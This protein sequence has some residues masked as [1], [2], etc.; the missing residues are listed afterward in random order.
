VQA[1]HDLARVS[2]S[3]DE[4]NLVPCAGLLPAAALAQ[5]LDVAGLVDERLRLVR[6]GANSGTKAMTVI[7]SMLAGGDSI[8]DTD[9]LRAGALPQLFDQ[10]RAPS[11]IGTWLRDFKWHN[12]RQLDAVSREMLVRQWS[13]GA[14]PAD[15]SASMTIDVDSTI[16]PVFGRGKQGADFGYTKV[17]GYHPQLATCAETG[18][19]LFARLRGGAAGAARGAKSF[20]TETFSRVRA[21]GVTGQLTLRADSAFYSKAVLHTAK[22]FNV[23]FSVTARQDKRIRAAIEAIE[24]SA[25]TPIPYWLSSP[26]VSGADVAETSFTAFTGTKYAMQVRLIVRRV[27]PTPGS[28]LA[29]FTTWDY[30]AFVTDRAGD[31]LELEADHRRHAIVEQSIAEL[32]SAGLAH[33]PSGKFMANAAWLALAVLAHNLARAVGLLAGGSLHR[34]TAATLR[35]AIF[36]MPGRLVRSGRRRCLRL[37]QNWPW[38]E[39][40]DT[41]LAAITA[42]EM[43]C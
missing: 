36:T 18:Q 28:Q 41:A 33:M 12:V 23:R 22:K 29:L 40:F 16:V 20:L 26:E 9:L 11:T 4:P 17:R 34:A 25:W 6:H 38:A 3:F 39:Q 21:A 14:G 13:V 30:H 2:A 10:G 32:K 27:R 37:P 15:L 35:R 24:Q 7:G 42:I 8:D 19:V 1:S 5:R 43:R 31:M